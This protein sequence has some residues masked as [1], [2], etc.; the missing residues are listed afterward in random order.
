MTMFLPFVFLV[1]LVPLEMCH[2]L[3]ILL[4]SSFL[5]YLAQQ[6][7]IGGLKIIRLSQQQ[8]VYTIFFI[9]KILFITKMQ[10]IYQ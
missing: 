4:I 9:L 1:Q 3:Q 10:G 6:T 2:L 5:L 8:S 7:N